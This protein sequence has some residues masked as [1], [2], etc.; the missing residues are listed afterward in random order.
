MHL[1]ERLGACTLVQPVDVLRDHRAHPAA[2]LELGE[3]EVPVVR[4]RLRERVEALPVE[5]PD[6]DGIG[7]E[8]VDR[9]VLH[10]VVLRP[11]AR[12][13]AE[14]RDAGL[15]AD[16]RSRQDDARLPLA[17][18]LRQPF[19]AHGR[20]NASAAAPITAA[21]ASTSATVTSERCRVKKLRVSTTA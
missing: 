2:A 8:R 7:E 6:L 12:G 16:A 3:R 21:A 15:R 9:R 1:D 17:D 18:E 20:R 13:R 10:R 4:L 11:E 5:L 19:D 14:V